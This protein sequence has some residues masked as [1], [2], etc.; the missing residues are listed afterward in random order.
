MQCEQHVVG[1]VLIRNRREM[2]PDNGP[3]IGK[4]EDRPSVP[5][6]TEVMNT[7]NGQVV[8]ERVIGKETLVCRVTEREVNVPSKR[9]LHI[10]RAAGR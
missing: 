8:D 3:V 4:V 5:D 7:L 6:I 1:Q 10:K 9:H 2:H